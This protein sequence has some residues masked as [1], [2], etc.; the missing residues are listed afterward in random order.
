MVFW[1][2]IK[3]VLLSEITIIAKNENIFLNVIIK[4]PLYIL[5]KRKPLSSKC[6]NIFQ[7]KLTF[8][9]TLLH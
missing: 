6:R 3:L 4:M 2:V 8:M 9:D 1:R 5:I 7:S